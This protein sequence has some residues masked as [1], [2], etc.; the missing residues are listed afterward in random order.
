MNKK[1]FT[2]I[3]IIVVIALLAAISVTVGVSMT[4]LF[5]K[6]EDKKYNA[7]ITEIENAA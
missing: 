4:G 2:L 5:G 1:G 6:E 3:E 7:Y